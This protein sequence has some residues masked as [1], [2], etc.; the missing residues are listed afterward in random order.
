MKWCLE[1]IYWVDHLHRALKSYFIIYASNVGLLNELHIF[2]LATMVYSAKKH[3]TN[4]KANQVISK[5][6]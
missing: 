2:S 4:G 5:N 3:Y 1:H 6:F